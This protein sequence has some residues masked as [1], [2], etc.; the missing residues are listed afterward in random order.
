[1]VTGAA[2]GVGRA[3][4]ERLAKHGWSVVA[5]DLNEELLGW[6]ADRGDVA[7]CVADISTEEGNQSI[8]DLAESQF[9]RLDAAI[10]NAGISISGP[11][12]TL[13]MEAF[14]RLIAVNLRGPVLGVR[15]SLPALRRAGGGAIAI[16]ASGYALG[17]DTGFWAY[18]AAKHG[19]LGLVRSVAREIAVEGIRINAACPSAI[20]GTGLS[21]P[22]EVTAPEV[23]KMIAE[24]IPLQRWCEPD[25]VASVLEFLVSD[26]SSFVNGVALPVDGGALTG[27][28]LLGPST[29]PNQF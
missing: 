8:V 3:T 22:I 17:G 2:Q 29:S 18:A 23:F 9:G 4:V 6:A 27:V 28:G 5:A 20:R 14:D 25:E 19:L 7:A 11:I 21:G 16:T 24:A 15:A 12:D 13:E 1:M 10:L 26:E